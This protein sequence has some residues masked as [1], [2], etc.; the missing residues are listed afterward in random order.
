MSSIR[1]SAM[2]LALAA[3][4]ACA[5]H[6][7][8]GDSDGASGEGG[9]GG[10]GGSSAS[11]GTGGTGMSGGSGGTSTTGGTGGSGEGGSDPTGGTGGTGV[12]T[13]GT[14]AYAGG[15]GYAGQGMGPPPVPVCG[16]P[17]EFD[18]TQLPD[19]EDAWG[20][21]SRLLYD[22]VREPP[23][24]LPEETTLEWIVEILRESLDQSRQ[25]SA[26]GRAAL[27]PFMRSFLMQ[28]EGS[29]AGDTPADYWARRM[30][31]EGSRFGDFFEGDAESNPP[32]GV[33]GTVAA[34]R[35]GL[36]ARGNLLSSMLT[37]NLV[38]PPPVTISSDPVVVGP[39][40]TRREALAAALNEQPVCSGCHT[41]MDPLGYPL[42]VFTPGTL[43]YR[44]TENGKPID[45]SGSVQ[46]LQFADLESLGA[47]AS[48][49][50]EVARCFATKIFDHISPQDVPSY[51]QA[52]LDYVVYRFTAPDS[53]ESERFQIQ[54]LLEAIVTTPSF[55]D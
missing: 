6:Y 54:E 31:A 16:A 20:R 10:A 29:A 18:F 50:C 7:D 22:E 48:V 38:G 36:S 33:F 53:P 28:N 32:F 9:S 35:D 47:Q 12:S 44:T 3:P 1:W 11:G 21:V 26:V 30:T 15:A 2:F 23:S 45:T 42:E 24:P 34:S 25:T 41:T 5:P 4:L 27:T 55:L 49:S 43:E 14:G 19:P 51:S 8:V 52:S 39:G 13:G 40:Q 17:V 37:C 46:G